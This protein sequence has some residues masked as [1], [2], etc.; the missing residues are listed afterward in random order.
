MNSLA[1]VV[2]TLPGLGLTPT[3][4]QDVEWTRFRGPNGT[5][6]CSSVSAVPD[7]LDPEG[8]SW[9]MA[10]P[11]GF[12]SPVLSADA[13]YFTGYE[14]RELFTIGVD[15]YTGELRWRK[16]APKPLDADP[17]GPNSPVS[18]SPATDGQ[19][20]YCLFGHCGLVSYDG[21]G[22]QR[23]FVELPE[24]NIP[25]GV[26]TSPVVHGDVL[27]LQADQDTGSYLLALNKDTGEELWRIERTGIT[28]GFSSP[29]IHQP[30]NGPAEVLVSSS[31]R[32][33][34]YSLEDGS[35]LWWIGGMA[36]QSKTLPVIDGDRLYLSSWMAPLT[37]LGIP[38]V[39]GVW[40]EV[41]Q[42]HD[43]DGDGKLSK[44]ESPHEAMAGLW[45]LFD[46]DN[47]EYLTDA[48]WEY[49]VARNS[50]D[51]ALYAISLANG[52]N[53]DRTETHVLWSYERTLP[54]IPSPVILDD[55][56]YVLK[57]GGILVC[58]D[59]E[60]G[61]VV[62]QG[63]VEGALDAYYSSPVAAAG[64]IVT[65][66]QS[67]QVAV[68]DTGE[69]WSVVSVTDFGEEIWSTAALGDDQIFVRTQ[70]HLY[71]FDAL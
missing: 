62:K 25:Y 37:E 3:G 38:R 63:R 48:D 30:E 8:A 28:H 35:E 40:E 27:L 51:S 9:S 45:F 14:G 44:E 39:T 6:V 32:L 21:D 16:S 29:S 2:L 1:S 60:S 33:T 11:A 36:W 26:G 41:L 69:E 15:R 46:L 50:A 20:V 23:W 64:R 10:A 43:A 57:E 52:P 55:R 5:G 7:A 19:N 49:V 68:L 22:E 18:P 53:G 59:A 34:A 56:V 67:G 70:G 61:E 65:T 12:S 4:P 58:L 17:R 66:S 42:K 47:D 54:N 71:C 13:V 24:W 31:Y